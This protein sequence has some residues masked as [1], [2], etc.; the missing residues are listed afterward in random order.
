MNSTAMDLDVFICV[1]KEA[2][3]KTYLMEVNFGE[4][5]EMY[6]GSLGRIRISAD[7]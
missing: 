4:C 7:K 5:T 3:S 1:D 2:K 6:N